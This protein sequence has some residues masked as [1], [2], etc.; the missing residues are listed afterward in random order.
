MR[1]K[2]W[3]KGEK[4][5]TGVGPTAHTASPWKLGLVY[6]HDLTASLLLSL[7]NLSSLIIAIPSLP[8]PTLALALPFYSFSRRHIAVF[9]HP[10]TYMD[11]TSLSVALHLSKLS[12]MKPDTPGKFPFA[13]DNPLTSLT[14]AV[15]YFLTCC[16]CKGSAKASWSHHVEKTLTSSSLPIFF[17][18]SLLISSPLRLCLSPN[19]PCLGC[20]WQLKWTCLLFSPRAVKRCT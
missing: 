18:S 19:C 6:K 16:H 12:T 11:H 9:I 8:F 14:H 13:A 15:V 2:D 7:F 10:D 1:E 3:E 4:G 17:Q 20:W 5:E